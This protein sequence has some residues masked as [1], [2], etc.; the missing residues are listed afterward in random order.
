[1]TKDENDALQT[2]LV[3]DKLA[4]LRME[5]GDYEGAMRALW[6]QDPKLPEPPAPCFCVG[7]KPG[8][9][10]CPCVERQKMNAKIDAKFA[11]ENPAWKEPK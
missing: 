11:R 5:R 2:A 6:M 1:M 8:H 4:G 9:T 3:K 10:D 7:P